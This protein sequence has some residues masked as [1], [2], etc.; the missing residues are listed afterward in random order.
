M[1]KEYGVGM[2]GSP[3]MYFIDSNVLLAMCQFYYK[4]KCNT[5]GII[6]ELKE[7]I[8]RASIIHAN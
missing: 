8:L 2:P 3:R 5:E 1:I 7:F 6:E 4:G